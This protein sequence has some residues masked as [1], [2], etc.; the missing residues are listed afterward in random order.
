MG[1]ALISSMITHIDRK[2]C[3][4]ITSNVQGLIQSFPYP[5]F[6]GS[7]MWPPNSKLLFLSLGEAMSGSCG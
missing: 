3:L 2:G 4:Y 7:F 1:T 6:R 5:K